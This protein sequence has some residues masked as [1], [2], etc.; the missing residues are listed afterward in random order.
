MLPW[1]NTFKAVW[2]SAMLLCWCTFTAQQA[3][4]PYYAH[5]LSLEVLECS[6]ILSAYMYVF[7]VLPVLATPDTSMW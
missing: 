2:E 7:P 5:L 6:N 1:H 4:L 3:L